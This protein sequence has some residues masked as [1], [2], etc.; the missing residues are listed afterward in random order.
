MAPTVVLPPGSP[1]APYDVNSG[2]VASTEALAGGLNVYARKPL[3][4]YFVLFRMN[5]STFWLGAALALYVPRVGT[6]QGAVTER[7][8]DLGVP[9]AGTPGSFNAITDVPGVQ[10]GYTT[11][12]RGGGVH[13]AG[14]GAAR[15]GVTVIL[16]KGKTAASY[17]AA[18]FSLNGDG[19]LTGIPS[20]EDFGMGAGGVGITNTN[21][22]GVVRDAV[23][24]WNFKHFAT[25]ELVDYSFGLPIVGE[26]WD[27]ILNDT[28]AFHVTKE[29]VWHALDEA[30]GGAISE[31]NV[32]GGTGMMLYGFKGGSGTSSRRIVID[33]VTYTVGV[34]VQA[35]FGSR[36]E[37]TIAGVPVGTEIPD[38]LPV[39][40]DP[41]KKDGSMIGVVVTD[42]PLLPSQ[43]K[44]VAR[45]VGHGVARTGSTSHNGSGE[46]FVAISTASPTYDTKG[47]K[48]SWSVIP[49]W[50]LDPI[51]EATVQATEE[52]IVN[53]LVAARDMEGMNDNKYF[54]LPHDR[55]QAALRKYNRI[56][57]GH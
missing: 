3:Y 11:I 19:E 44:L 39:L 26:T 10:V 16:P 21:S 32:G 48:E 15:T 42:A 37:L 30:H 34:F 5:R 13:P 25:G 33:S 17:P 1:S 31:G 29:D 20:V 6:A 36:R 55:L 38:H 4:P 24:E 49:K 54:A 56:G 9:F 18:Y 2:A 50:K 45:R 43:L 28:Y 27:G 14:K 40:H 47:S 22:V 8:R 51:F 41:K 57:T 46:I 12:I 7:A 35:N 53:A 52:A 23:G